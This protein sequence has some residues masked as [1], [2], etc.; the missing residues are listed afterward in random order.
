MA[1]TSFALSKAP[2]VEAVVDIDCDL[3]PNVDVEALDAAGKAAYS[4]VYPRAQR[5]MF[6]T[7]QAVMVPRQPPQFTSSEGWQALQY[8][9]EDGQQLV[10]VR[11]NGFS[12][13]R[14]VPYSSLDDYLPEIERTWLLFKELA[15]P[16]VC[17]AVR[18][19]YI[20]RIELPL[21]DGR[22]ELGD[23]LTSP[24]H[25]ADE[26]R[27][28]L[29][30]FFEQQ[31]VAETGTGHQAIVVRTSQLP[32]ANHLPLI[33]DITVI[34]TGNVEPSDWLAISGRIAQ[35]RNLKNLIFRNALTQRCLQL[36]QQ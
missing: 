7:H 3:P 31:T 18:M 28:Q 25:L 11:P 15:H 26:Q 23:F 8:L 4:D 20:N 19:R 14:L 35:L 17:R 5:R 10:Q 29:T 32:I 6:N 12:F 22:I 16:L 2:I 1:E 13:N 30:G 34:A 24:P 36:F 33:Y 21:V 9:S 27:L